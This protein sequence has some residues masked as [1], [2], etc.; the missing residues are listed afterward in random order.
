MKL[1][2]INGARFIARRVMG[3][4]G[5]AVATVTSV[6]VAMNTVIWV[7]D[8][9]RKFS[10]QLKALRSGKPFAFEVK[11]WIEHPEL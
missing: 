10:S 7:T 9:G 2:P 11:E 1:Q 8:N 4:D 3:V 5:P 6:N